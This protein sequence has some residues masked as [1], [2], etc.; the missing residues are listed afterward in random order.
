MRVIWGVRDLGFR[1]GCEFLKAAQNSQAD[2]RRHAAKH[3][4]PCFDDR[5]LLQLRVFCCVSEPP[6]SGKIARLDHPIPAC[7]IV[8]VT[9]PPAL[10]SVFMVSLIAA[11]GVVK[12]A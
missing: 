4:P 11:T 8:A 7:R 3:R 6:P 2:H 5:A 9:L 1:V 12:A 10:D